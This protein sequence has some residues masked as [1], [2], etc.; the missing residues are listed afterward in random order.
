[1]LVHTASSA[2]PLIGNRGAAMCRAALSTA[3]RKRRRVKPAGYMWEPEWMRCRAESNSGC[4]HSWIPL[5][6]GTTASGRRLVSPA[7]LRSETVDRD[8]SD[9]QASGPSLR[10]LKRIEEVAVPPISPKFRH[11]TDQVKVCHPTIRRATA[12]SRRLR[13]DARR[14]NRQRVLSPT[15]FLSAV[16]GCAGFDFAREMMRPIVRFRLRPS[17][18]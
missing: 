3:S 17:F 7:T 1:M 8:G 9:P 2:S 12:F 14:S 10:S 4:R 13:P 5:A 18:S 6:G 11:P 15:Q 16:N